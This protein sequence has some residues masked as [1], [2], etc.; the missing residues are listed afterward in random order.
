MDVRDVA[1]AAATAL[2]T[3]D[4]DGEAVPLVGPEVLSGEACARAWSEA[5]GRDVTYGG[6]DLPAWEAQARQMLPP[7]MAWDFRIMYRMFLAP[8]SGERRRTWRPPGASW[9]RSRGASRPSRGRWRGCG[10]DG[11]LTRS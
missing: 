3:S 4:F 8:D 10:P 6:H 1:T 7:W 2:L 11:V 9:A 5:L